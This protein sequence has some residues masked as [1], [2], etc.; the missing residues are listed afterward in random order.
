MP[1]DHRDVLG[2]QP[3]DA[4]RHQ[5][6]NPLNLRLAQSVVAFERQYDGRARPFLLGREQATLRHGQ[7]HTSPLH[8]RHLGDR[9]RQ[10][11]LLRAT[12]IELLHELGLADVRAIE[13]LVSDSA[14]VREA[15]GRQLKPQL[16]DLGAGHQDRRPAG[17]NLVGHFQFFQLL[18]DR[19]RIVRRKIRK[20][21][22][23][24]GLLRPESDGGQSG[25]GRGQHHENR[26][27]T[28]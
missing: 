11:A 10:L 23:H 26:D 16:I 8:V 1:V 14:A 3:F 5:V 28:G 6:H 4:V 7:V 22:L 18:D 12:I 27:A 24:I 21:Q 15:L 20:Q 9:T 17:A 25:D 2:L 13:D 19:S